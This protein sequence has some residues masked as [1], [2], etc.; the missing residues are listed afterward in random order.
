VDSTPVVEQGAGFHLEHKSFSNHC[1]LCEAIIST[2]HNSL[3]IYKQ[4]NV[5]YLLMN[6]ATES[7]KGLHMTHYRMSTST[8]KH[9]SL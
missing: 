5:S 7:R 3:H 4:Q 9:F 1:L 8:A 2:T 6:T